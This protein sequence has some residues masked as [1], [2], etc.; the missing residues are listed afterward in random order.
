MNEKT[1]GSNFGR[2]EPSKKEN[3]TI[4]ILQPLFGER[5]N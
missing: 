4:E 2:E 5:L 1:A 3:G